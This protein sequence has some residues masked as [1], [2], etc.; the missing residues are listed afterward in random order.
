MKP[1]EGFKGKV[2]I[3]RHF[4][5]LWLLS[6]EEIEVMAKTGTREAGQEPA[7]VVLVGEIMGSW[8]RGILQERR[9]TW[10]M[11]CEHRVDVTGSYVMAVGVEGR[12]LKVLR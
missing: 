3:Y 2:V 4:Y 7:A 11:C 6:G 8:V 10:G 1:L 5:V 9:A 12:R